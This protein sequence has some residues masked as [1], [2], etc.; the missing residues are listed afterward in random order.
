MIASSAPRRA[1]LP[2]SA[3]SAEDTSDGEGR[4]G[5]VTWSAHLHPRGGSR[6]LALQ[7]ADCQSVARG[8]VLRNPEVNRGSRPPGGDRA[9]AARLDAELRRA[10]EDLGSD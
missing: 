7:R 8:K 5:V 10:L 2:G 9:A 4:E 3:G 1:S 6:S